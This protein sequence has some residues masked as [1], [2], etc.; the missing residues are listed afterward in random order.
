MKAW[1][2][3]ETYLDSLTEKQLVD[4]PNLFLA[5]AFMNRQRGEK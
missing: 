4:F 2:D 3:A 1:I 5:S